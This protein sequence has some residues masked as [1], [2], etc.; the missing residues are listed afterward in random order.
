MRLSDFD[1]DLPEDRIALRPARPRDA[2]RLLHIPAA[3]RFGDH[4]VLELPDLLQ[5][6]DVLVLNDTRVLHAALAGVRPARDPDG[7]DVKVSVNLHKRE[8]DCRWRVFAKPGKRLRVGD[9]IA[10][11]GLRARIEAKSDGGDFLIHFNVS[12]RKL[13]SAIQRCGAPPLPPYIASKR[14]VDAS[15]EEDYQTTFAAADKAESVAAPTAGLHF[16][17]RLMAALD[18]RGV[19]RA[20]VTLHVGAGTF[21]PVKSENVQEHQMHAEWCE[22]SDSTAGLINHAKRDGK[23]IVP[24]GTTALRTL[25]SMAG[26]DGLR[27]GSMETAIFITPGYEFRMTDALLTNFHLPKSTLF[28]LVS[29]LAGLDRMQAAYA[30]AIAERYRFFSYGD[31]C[32]IEAAE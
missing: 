28:M 32:L 12:G 6:G 11:E 25:E 7:G 30:H 1:F 29:A 5:P 13:E 4:G 21:L 3:G 17:D 8:G 19:K 24:V 9:E 10:F 22:V 23:R 2:A 26:P 18:A 16:T 14:S 20:T 27:A 31:A 15:D